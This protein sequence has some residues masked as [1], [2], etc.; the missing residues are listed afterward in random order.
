MEITPN[1]MRR[2]GTILMYT[3]H[4]KNITNRHKLGDELQ[5]RREQTVY[6]SYS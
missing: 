6:K 1:I 3:S 5:E 4:L 2:L